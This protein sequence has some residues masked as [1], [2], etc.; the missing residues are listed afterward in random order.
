MSQL[1]G[2]EP[3]PP[4]GA[5]SRRTLARGAAW[6]VPVMVIGVP[7][8]AATASAQDVSVSGACRDGVLGPTITFRVCAVNAAMLAGST[9]TLTATRNAF[10]T[11]G[12]AIS[13]TFAANSSA[14]VSSGRQISYTTTRDLGAGSC[15]SLSL[16]FNGVSIFNSTTTFTLGLGSSVGNT[17][18]VTTNDSAT[19][20]V[21]PVVF[22]V[23]VVCA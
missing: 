3:G 4:D 6:S 9:F 14:T 12:P 22:G 17:N 8:L 1:S 15:W 16:S 13:G 10:D 11:A 23:G 7:A 5:L 2:R 20:G 19:A 18:T 21:R